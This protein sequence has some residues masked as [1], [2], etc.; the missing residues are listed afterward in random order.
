MTI[1]IR[2]GSEEHPLEF[3]Q[4]NEVA[5][6]PRYEGQKSYDIRIRYDSTDQ[7]IFYRLSVDKPRK[8]TENFTKLSWK[9]NESKSE[10]T[11]NADAA[12]LEKLQDAETYFKD[13]YDKSE[14]DKTLNWKILGLFENTYD[15]Q[16]VQAAADLQNNV[17]VDNPQIQPYINHAK[18]KLRIETENFGSTEIYLD[19]SP[20][21]VFVNDERK[22]LLGERICLPKGEYRVTLKAKQEIIGEKKIQ[23]TEGKTNREEIQIS[24]IPGTAVITKNEAIPKT[25]LKRTLSF[26]ILASLLAIWP[27]MGTWTSPID[28]GF[29]AGFIIITMIALSYRNKLGLVL[30]GIAYLMMLIAGGLQSFVGIIGLIIIAII[31]YQ[32]RNEWSD[33]PKKNK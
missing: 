17:Y 32:E 29:Y 3:F 33:R 26:A 9:F 16:A 27:V 6:K 30:L 10:V 5:F 23:I 20:V 11:L 8:L 13:L 14:T 21:E 24:P 15:Y 2:I 4:G 31:F 25:I 1:F 18:E 28:L 19:P 7:R 22:G 12:H